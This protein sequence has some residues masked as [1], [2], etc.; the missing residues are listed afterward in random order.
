MNGWMGV[1]LRI[2]LS[3]GRI[4]KEPLE[5]NLVYKYVGGRGLNIKILFDETKPGIDPLGP[6]NK[7]IL[8]AGPCNGTLAPGSCRLTITA[9][10]PITGFFGC[11]NSGGSF[12]KEIKYAG[13]DV[14]IIERRECSKTYL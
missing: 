7:M 1:I 10:S 13:Y 4:N 8:G 3:G 12:G 6:H 14:I 9:R 2:D 11:S 5:E